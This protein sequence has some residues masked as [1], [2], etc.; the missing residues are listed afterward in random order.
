MVCIH[1]PGNIN[2]LTQCLWYIIRDFFLD[3]TIKLKPIGLLSET[4]PKLILHIHLGRVH[5]KLGMIIIIQICKYFE[6]LV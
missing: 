2:S 4:F 5:N 1:I 3:V 6:A